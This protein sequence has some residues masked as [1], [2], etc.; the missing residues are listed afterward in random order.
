[1]TLEAIGEREVSDETIV[2]VFVGVGSRGEHSAVSG[3]GGG[4][5][6]GGA[7][8]GCQVLGEMERWVYMALYGV[9]DE[10]EVGLMVV[11]H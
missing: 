6:D 2:E 3:D 5:S 11:R 1:M 10:E 7:G 8:G 4:E 9:C